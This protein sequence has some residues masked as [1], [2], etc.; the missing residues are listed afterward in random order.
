M[1]D[2]IGDDFAAIG[3]VHTFSWLA[4][5]ARGRGLG[6]EARTAILQLAFEGFDA[7]EAASDAFTDNHASNRVSEALGYTRNGTCW[8]TR[9]GAAAELLRWRMTREDWAPRRRADIEL[10]G[11]TECKPILG[12]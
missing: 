9:R 3:T 2:L 10:N 6:K 4:P 11:V 8:A 7:R 5:R 1:Q 12:L